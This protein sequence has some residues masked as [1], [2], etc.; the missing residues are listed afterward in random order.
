[1]IVA[2]VMLLLTIGIGIGF[3]GAIILAT[4]IDWYRTRR[5]DKD[6]V[7]EELQRTDYQRR[8]PAAK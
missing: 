1:M 4:I 3:F 8:R 7:W 5:D 2:Q 6:R